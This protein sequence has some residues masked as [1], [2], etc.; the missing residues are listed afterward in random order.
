VDHLTDDDQLV[1]RAF[2]RTRL[3]AA[4][5]GSRPSPCARPLVAGLVLASVTAGGVAWPVLAEWIG[6]AGR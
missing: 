2:R 4:L 5:P 1:A 6:A 3:A